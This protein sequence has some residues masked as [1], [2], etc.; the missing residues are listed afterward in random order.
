MEI[1]PKPRQESQQY[2]RKSQQES[3]KYEKLSGV[4]FINHLSDK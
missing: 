1:N 4:F 2:G 3:G